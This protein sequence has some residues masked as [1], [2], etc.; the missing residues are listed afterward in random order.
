M[1]VQDVGNIL[2]LSMSS[3]QRNFHRLL[4]EAQ[5]V[6]TEEMHLHLVV[7]NCKRRG[8]RQFTES[9]Q[10]ES[11]VPPDSFNLNTLSHTCESSQGLTSICYTTT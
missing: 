5:L 7:E 11:A 4:C 8:N 2:L 9:L 10:C 3:V 6:L 1:Y